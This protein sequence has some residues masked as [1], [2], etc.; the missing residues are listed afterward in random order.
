MSVNDISSLFSFIGGLGMFLY[1]MNIMADGMQKTAGS[2]MSQ[3]LG[4]LTNNRLM[5]VLLGA[6]ITAIIQSSGAT[7]VMVVGFVS[8]GVLNLTQA[9]GVIMGANIGTTITAWIVSMNQ[10]GDAFAVFQPAFFAPLLIGI[11]A[12]FMLFGKKQ[13]MKTAGEILVGLGLLFIGLDFM[14]SSISPY[15]DAPVFSEAFRL[16]GS[17]PLLGMIIG[18]LVTALLQSSSASVGILQTLAING[19]VTTNAA[20]FITLG[21]NIGSCVTAMISSIGGS[22]T[23]KR[24]AVIHLTFNVMGAVIFGVI[25]FILFSLHPVLAAHNI[26]SVQISIFHTIFNLTNTALLFP[27][28]NQLVKLSGVFVPED[29]KETAV[30]DEESETMKHLDE[31][32]FESPAF[33]VE[34]AAMEVVHMGQITMENVRRAMDAVLTKNANEVEDVYKTEQT[35]NNMEKM[36]TEYLVKVNNLSLTE[37]QKL[38]VNDLFYSI[39]DIERVGDHAENLAEQAEYMVQHNIS[40]SETGESDLHVICETAFNSFKHS[41]NARQKGDMDD[42]RKVS[43]Y[44]DEVDTLE[45]ELREKHIERLSAGKCDPSAGVVFLDLISNLERISDHAYNLAGYVKDEM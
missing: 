33:A 29:K 14:S 11:G 25:S 19:V 31:R 6:L 9:V 36:L 45:E 3:F 30:T 15:T 34:T 27:F 7:T 17:N 28:A 21:Q 38:V 8:A 42:V 5:A 20:I 43:Q 26:T 18:A 16:L 37:R 39:N 24:A 23:A 44:E 2:K 12:I 35:I 22:R 4:M 40:F 41:I 32:I 13:R 1:G 10:L